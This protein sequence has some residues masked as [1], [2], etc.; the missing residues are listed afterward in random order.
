MVLSK[1]FVDDLKNG[2]PSLY[3]HCQKDGGKNPIRVNLFQKGDFEFPNGSPFRY[4]LRKHDFHQVLQN[5][6]AM[7]YSFTLFHLYYVLSLPLHGYMPWVMRY[8]NYLAVFRPSSGWRTNIQG[9]I[10]VC[11]FKETER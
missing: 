9:P 6:V 3:G 5:F 4:R 7:L 2:M 10:S 1:Y 11:D 8:N